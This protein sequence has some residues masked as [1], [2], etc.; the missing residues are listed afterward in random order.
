MTLR[1]YPQKSTNEVE[2]D[3]YKFLDNQIYRLAEARI[4]WSWNHKAARLNRADLSSILFTEAEEEI[5]ELFPAMIVAKEIL[6]KHH[7]IETREGILPLEVTF[8][9][10]KLMDSEGIVIQ[11]A[12]SEAR[13]TT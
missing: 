1:T 2:Y 3:E 10:R 7:M 5:V 12:P 4:K 8:P 6:D 9:V 11:E 13:V